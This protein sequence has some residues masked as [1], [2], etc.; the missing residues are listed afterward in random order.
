MDAAPSRNRR[1]VSNGP[2]DMPDP[3]HPEPGQAAPVT[4]NYRAHNVF[5]A[6]IE[7][8]VRML[9]MAA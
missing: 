4:G 9:S 1:A 8:V 6:P 2:G 3:Q 5:G 7:R